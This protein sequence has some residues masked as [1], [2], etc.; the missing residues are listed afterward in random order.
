MRIKLWKGKEMIVFLNEGKVSLVELSDFSRRIN[1]RKEVK[2]FILKKEG[3]SVIL[4]DLNLKLSEKH[5]AVFTET[6]LTPLDILKLACSILER[7]SR[8][9][10][11]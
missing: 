3:R 4:K 9:L 5:F 1:F 2:N 10:K 6:Y 8:F 7:R 11:R